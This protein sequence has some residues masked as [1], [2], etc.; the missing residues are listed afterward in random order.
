MLRHFLKLVARDQQPV[1]RGAIE[2]LMQVCQM[3]RQ[4]VLGFD[5]QLR[6]C[7]RRRRAQVSNKIGNGEIGFMA[8]GGNYWKRESGDATGER[9]IVEGS[10]I[11]YRAA[12]AGNDDDVDV[13]RAIEIFH[14][15]RYFGRSGFTLHLSGVNQNPDIF[16]AARQDVQHVMQRGATGRGNDADAARQRRNGLAPRRVE[17]S[18]LRQPGLELL[19]LKLQGAGAHRLQEFSGKLKL[20]ACVVYSDAPS[21]DDLHAA[22]RAEAQKPR[23]AAEHHDAQLRVAILE[24]EVKMAGFRRAEIGDLALHPDVGVAAFHGGADRA[25]QIGHAPDSPRGRLLKGEA[26]LVVKSHAFS[27]FNREHPGRFARA[28]SVGHEISKSSRDG[29]G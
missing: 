19:K 13:L 9:F 12:A 21:G 23:L 3:F 15:G 22:L 29:K 26:E 20:A 14:A 17:Q 11:F 8:N 1:A 16:M 28:F 25:Y 24:R 27:E 10:Q 7:G 4:A 5:Y 2:P 6:R 18:F